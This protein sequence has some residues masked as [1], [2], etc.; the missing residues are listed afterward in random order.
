[1]TTGLIKNVKKWD[2]GW[3]DYQK[4]RG[5]LLLRHIQTLQTHT[6]TSDITEGVRKH[7]QNNLNKSNSVEL[8]VQNGDIRV[9]HSE[10]VC[11][12]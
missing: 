1:M 11:E 6:Q 10:T 5:L 3:G 8:A 7:K 2:E 12:I 4:H 9:S